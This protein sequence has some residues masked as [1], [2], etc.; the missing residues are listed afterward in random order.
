MLIEAPFHLLFTKER[1]AQD[2]FRKSFCCEAGDS[3]I[4][5]EIWFSER[6]D[7]E[8][9][10]KATKISIFA[11]EYQYMYWYYLAKYQKG[12]KTVYTL[13]EGD[14]SSTKI[15]QE[16]EFLERLEQLEKV[17]K[18]I[19]IKEEDVDFSY[20][21][22]NLPTYKDLYMISPLEGFSTALGRNQQH[23][24]LLERLQELTA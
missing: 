5:A 17:A 20:M 21:L 12:E 18:K 2:A 6:K 24:C 23:R 4:E 1:I 19:I 3:I 10:V 9:M 13:Q 7:D 8:N 11:K 14:S 15:V 16:E 22:A